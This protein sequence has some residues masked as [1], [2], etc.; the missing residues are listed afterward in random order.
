VNTR[1]Q[2][3]P[4]KSLKNLVIY[5]AARTGFF[6]ALLL[7]RKF[8]LWLFGS[9]GRVVFLFSNREKTRTLEHLRMIFGA[10]W[11]E[12]TI[13]ET[14]R[15][16]YVAL[17]KNIFDAVKLSRAPHRRFNDL[18]KHDDL[19]EFEYLY[20]LGQGVIV[21]TAHVGCFEMLL[22]FFARHGFKS[23]TIGRRSFD[24]RLD[25]LIRSLRS[26]EDISFMDRSESPRKI[27]RWL[28]EGGAFGVLIDQDTRVEGVFA[29]FL[30]TLA[31]TPSAPVRMAMRYNIPAVVATTVRRPD[32]THYVYISD[33]LKFEYTGD[34]ERDLIT[35]V[36]MANNLIGQTI[37]R[38]PEQ[39]VW[40]HRRW[41][42]KP[43]VA[44]E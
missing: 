18:V 26:G 36:G 29:P 23:L 25:G 14:A 22:H 16:V 33:R 7:P 5:C 19:T 39:W 17:G 30:G 11:N 27:L 8:G 9:L 21:I 31:H 37:M 6:L 10:T 28:R 1:P 40:M 12:D 13:G 42:T 3:P 35:N 41:K 24:S 43:P 15:N 2:K 4:L 38:F 32:D 20:S 44:P 34:F